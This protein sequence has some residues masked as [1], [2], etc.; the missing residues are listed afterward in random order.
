MSD[1]EP[2]EPAGAVAPLTAP[3][4]TPNGT[5][6]LA[7]RKQDPWGLWWL[8][9]ITFSVYYYIWYARVNDE[10]S[11]ILDEPNPANGQWW[12]QLVPIW[13][14]VGLAATAKRLNAAHAKVGSP[15]RVGIFTTW[16]WAS[17][18]FASQ[19]RY[20]QR[21]INILHDVLAAK[22]V[23]H[24]PTPLASP[25]AASLPVADELAKL[26]TLRDQGILSPEEF[27]ARKARLLG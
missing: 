20:L 23:V 15:T 25:S 12:N 22:T 13:N 19:T 18:W 9:I 5:V 7:P 6:T 10:L 4:P 17:S 24:D 21:R 14:L 16:F 1:L 3:T 26:A 2:S 27:E 11:L 8:C